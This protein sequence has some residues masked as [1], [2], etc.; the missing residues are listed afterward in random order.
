MN[1][2]RHEQDDAESP[3]GRS[4]A[5]SDAKS[6]TITRWPLEKL[7]PH[8]RQAELFDDLPST[9]R[10]ELAKNM[11]EKGL[12]HPIEALPDGTI[13]CGHQRFEAARRLG[14]KEIDV[15]VRDDL[16]NQGDTAVQQWMIEDNLLRRQQDPV[17]LARSY[18]RLKELERGGR[19]TSISTCPRATASTNTPT[20]PTALS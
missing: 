1:N 4:R 11:R 15:W 14:W 3:N 7:K 17:A 2:K 16:A 5:L 6:R 13:I 9:K 19:S 8:P 10:V 18:K 12:Q 20:M